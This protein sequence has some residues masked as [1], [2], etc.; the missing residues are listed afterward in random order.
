MEIIFAISELEGF[1][2][3]G[4]LADVGKALP[5][6]LQ[7]RGHDIRVVIPYYRIIAEKID[8]E[9]IIEN[10]IVPMGSTRIW[11]SV[12]FKLMENVPVY[13]I[14]NNLFFFRSRF[15]DDGVDAFPDNAERFGFFS[16]A[17]LKLCQA[18][19]FI[20][21]IVH[22]NDWHTALIPYYLKEHEQIHSLFCDT[23]AVLTVHNAA[24]QGKFDSAVNNFLG[25]PPEHF[26]WDRFE[27]YGLINFLKGGL[28]SADK[29]NTVSRGYANELLTYSGSHGL[30]GTFH[31]RKDDFEGILN[32]CDY[33][34]WHPETDPQ[35]PARYNMRNMR[36]KVICK[37]ELQRYYHLPQHAHVP[38]IGIITRLTRQKGFEYSLPAI[39]EILNWDIQFAVLGAGESWIEHRFYELAKQ[40][41]DKLGWMNG[42]D[43]RLAHLIEAGCDMFLMPSLYEPCGLNQLYSLKYGTV[44]LVR[45][46]G[47][48]WDT[49]ENY[50]SDKG[51]GTGFVFHDPTPQGVIDCVGIAVN[52]FYDRKHHFNQ[53][54]QSGMAQQFDWQSSAENYEKLYHKALQ[55]IGKSTPDN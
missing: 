48:L 52:T 31:Y 40:Y 3:T 37:L 5:L 22:A 46:V 15:Y 49:V 8:T 21:D 39:E 14:E 6:A 50:D 36:G 1:A 30:H 28:I 38:V 47:G 41:P 10:M 16:R 53:L 4:G 11:C 25:I 27:D 44:P 12:R 43:W 20:P 13:F 54:I 51:C 35:I 26:T 23:A 55:K 19:E 9:L 2:K 29:I 18:L 42:Y 24:F 32:G 7:G 34:E 33:H 17:V 45:G